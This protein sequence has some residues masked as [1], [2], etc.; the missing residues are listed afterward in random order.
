MY[1]DISKK[2]LGGI[3]TQ[4]ISYLLPQNLSTDILH[5]MLDEAHSIDGR[6]MDEVSTP[7]LLLSIL[8]LTGG[9]FSNNK[10]EVKI[11]PDDLVNYC[12]TYI[13]TLKMEEMRR[14]NKINITEEY[15]PTINNICGLV[16]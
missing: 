12:N 14:S 15:L 9:S 5:H 8:H 16:G 10:M 3:N 2:L 11:K 6:S 7:L 13:T 4:G 1:N